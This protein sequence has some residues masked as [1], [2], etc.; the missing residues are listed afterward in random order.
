MDE[1]R[2][3]EG[4]KNA[5]CCKPGRPLSDKDMKIHAVESFDHYT[6]LVTSTSERC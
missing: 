1:S 6:C 3:D 4:V 2:K 5:S